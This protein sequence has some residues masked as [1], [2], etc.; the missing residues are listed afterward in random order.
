MKLVDYIKGLIKEVNKEFFDEEKDNQLV[1]DSDETTIRYLSQIG[2]RID[3]SEGELIPTLEDMLLNVEGLLLDNDMSNAAA[4][5]VM[6]K[7]MRNVIEGGD[8]F[9]VWT[10]EAMG[11]V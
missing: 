5:R 11:R 3:E 8:K 2:K 7:L 10:K 1:K 9:E 6:C 4:V